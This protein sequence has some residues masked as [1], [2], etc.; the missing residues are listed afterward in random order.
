MGMSRAASYW[1]RSGRGAAATL[2]ETTNE[3]KRNKNGPVNSTDQGIVWSGATSFNASASWFDCLSF[4]VRMFFSSL[5]GAWTG[6]GF[7]GRTLEQG[8]LLLIRGRR[9]A[10]NRGPTCPEAEGG[11][12]R[13]VRG[14]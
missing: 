4:I 13:E 11:K 14:L 12:Q 7:S 8:I 3:V 10:T 2:P 1:L 6:E 9:T 5:C